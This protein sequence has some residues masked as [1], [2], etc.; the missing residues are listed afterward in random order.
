MAGNAAGCEL[1][2][3][4][5]VHPEWAALEGGSLLLH[6]KA[7][8]LRIAQLQKG[9]Y[10]VA[11]APADVEARAS[12]RPWAEVT[13]L[14]FVEPLG[15]RRCRL[16]SRYRCACSDDIAMRLRMGPSLLEPIGFAMDR[17]M[18]MGIKERAERAARR[19]A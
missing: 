10:L 14:F 1:R 19:P 17:R 8:P 6:P 4:E 11:H 2:N 3:A 15:D 9:R 12:G 18:L 7:P 13:W 5:A 16:I